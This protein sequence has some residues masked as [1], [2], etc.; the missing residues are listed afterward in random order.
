MAFDAREDQDSFFNG[1][2]F[3][4]ARQRLLAAQRHLA[5]GRFQPGLF[6]E[7]I[8]VDLF[9]GAGGASLGLKQALGRDPT[10]CV[11]HDPAAIA[12]QKLNTP[13]A[14][15]YTSDV[16]EVDPIKAV[17]GRPVGIL[18]MSPTCIHFSSAKGGAPLDVES[19]R[20]IRGL[21]WVG[22]RWAKA[23]RPRIIMCENVPGFL[24]WARLG[25]DGRVDKSRIDKNGY[26]EYFKKWVRQLRGLGYS[27]EWRIISAADFGS[28][29][30][31]RRVFIIARCDGLPL[32]W[33]TPT[34][35][36]GR[37]HPYRTT[38]ECID[39]SIKTV[40]I[41]ASKQQGRRHG[42]KRPLKDATLHRIAKGI[43]RFVLAADDPYIVDKNRAP[44][45][46]TLNHSGDECRAQRV[47]EPKKTICAAR[48][49]HGVV[50]AHVTRFRTGSVGAAVDEPLNTITSGQ[51]S[52]RPA[53]HAHAMGIVE[54]R[55]VRFVDAAA[56]IV[57]AI[58]NQSS[59]DGCAYDARA[60]LGTIV[61]ENRHAVVEAAFVAQQNLG[62]VGRPID[63][64]LAT[65]TK[66][67]SQQQLVTACLTNF[68]G[69]ND[70]GSRGSLNE[71]LSAITAGGY[72]QGLVTAELSGSDLA[73]AQ[74]VARFLKRYYR[75]GKKDPA[76]LVDVA[77]GTLTV[78][79]RT[80]QITDISLRM[81]AVKELKLAQGFP[82][83][84]RLDPVCEYRTASG[85][86]YGPLPQSEQIAKI[87]NSVCPQV[88]RALA[89]AN[90]FHERPERIASVLRRRRGRRASAAVAA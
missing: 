55:A 40:S 46:S 77:R 33:P 18:W 59:G 63:E 11:N 53:G 34:H 7:E 13:G 58:D 80:I 67:G 14:E 49:A 26:G 41:F 82:E 83:S 24:T 45:I 73:A 51:G 4:A 76:L 62:A 2:D 44:F 89:E 3:A 48:D 88:A 19:A 32:V 69:T 64:P 25:K 52:K 27:V 65:V 6:G 23:V 85:T 20:K 15:C 8:A 74:R 35:G 86:K 12:C 79:G 36:P 31:R 50:L 57:V 72:H 43:V 60:P 68:Y 17:A 28:P 42:V 70:G 30:I 37:E 78:R 61:R 84:Y 87:G 66:T 1:H 22:V 5:D 9:A 21:A 38:A 90:L 10:I 75:P 47:D 81:M 56:P 16:F 71:P 54:A 39:W 29:T